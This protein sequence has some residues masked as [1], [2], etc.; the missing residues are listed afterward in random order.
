MDGA[1]IDPAFRV[2]VVDEGGMTRVFCGV[3]CAAAWLLRHGAPREIRVTDIASGRELD[4]RTASYARTL[5]PTPE[6]APDGIRVFEDEATAR[7]HARAHGGKVLEGAQR[8]FAPPTG[9][10]RAHE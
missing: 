3:R 5:G 6:G 7:A 2:R 9:G 8:P 4:G 1:A 10:D